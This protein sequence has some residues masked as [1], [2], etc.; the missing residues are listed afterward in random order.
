MRI[1]LATADDLEPIVALLAD[2]DLGKQR[3]QLE[4]PLPPSYGRAFQTIVED[5]HSE[6]YVGEVDGEV[7]GTFQLNFLTYLTY[8]GGRRAQIEAVRIHRAHRGRG[9]GRHLFGW[10]IQRAREKGCHLVQLTTDKARPEALKFYES[11]GFRA[12]HEGLK[13]SL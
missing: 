2:D 13:L 3:E 12:S 7:A 4:S 8:Q 11:L 5:R 1:R 10:A 6:L 9:W